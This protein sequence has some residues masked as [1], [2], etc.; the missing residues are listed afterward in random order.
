V[1]LLP[2]PS[3][4]PSHATASGDLLGAPAATDRPRWLLAFALLL[5]T[6][7]TT[8]T[9]GAVW[10]VAARTDLPVAP[11]PIL[12]WG[13]ILGVWSDPELLRLGLLFSTAALTI[14]LCHELGHY[15]ACRYYRL[16]AT[17]P[18]FL[19]MPLALGT[20]GAFIR[21][22]S[23]IRSRRQLFDVGIAGP[24]AGFAAL[25]PFL[26]Y[27]L[28][29]SEVSGF[30][31]APPEISDV[32]LQLPGPSLGLLLATRLVHGA[33][34]DGILN[35]HP[36]VLA[37]W[38]GL[39]ATA[40]N[41][42]PLGQLDGGHILYAAAPRLFRRLGWPLWLALAFCGLLWPGWWVWCL[43][44]L[45]VSGLRHPPVADEHIPLDR[46]RRVLAW[47]ALLLLM[48]SFMPSPIR[49]LTA[50]SEPPAGSVLAAAEL[51]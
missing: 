11:D 10:V 8:T 29:H 9:L 35:Y 1:E 4:S 51:P 5:I 18:Y 37:A 44:V 50:T 27:G 19:P 32:G 23:P 33:L 28:A 46:R 39:F 25:L 40:L 16:P 49:Q 20:M 15:L 30:R 42:L 31:P 21:I 7:W 12:T 3:S 34:G 36:F 13:L 6:W 47:V 22:R 24:L 17:L 38:F 2:P 41:L 48:L 14:L 45:F 43:V 26:V